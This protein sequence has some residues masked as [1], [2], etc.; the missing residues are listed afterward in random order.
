MNKNDLYSIIYLFNREIRK[1]SASLNLENVFN[2]AAWPLAQDKMEAEI[3][4]GK[5][6]RVHRFN[7]DKMSRAANEIESGILN[8][9]TFKVYLV[10]EYIRRNN[11]KFLKRKKNGELYK[12]KGKSNK[13]VYNAVDVG[14]IGRLDGIE[15]YKP[16]DLDRQIKW[17]KEE[18]AKHVSV[19]NL[20]SDQKNLL[21]KFVCDGS[22]GMHLYIQIWKNNDGFGID[23]SKSRDEEYNKFVKMA[24]Y[25]VNCGI[26]LSNVFYHG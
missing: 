26:D 21:Y 4:F 16:S 8:M 24:K 10:G 5:G 22:I 6:M 7:T 3:A 25:L 2:E 1:T 20:D 12:P 13:P 9:S 18:S 14:E 15:M 11:G 19:L 23:L 17:L